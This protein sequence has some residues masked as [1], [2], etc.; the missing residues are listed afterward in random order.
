MK[1]PILTAKAK[2]VK[3]KTKVVYG[4]GVATGIVATVWVRKNIPI[5]I[6]APISTTQLQHLIDHTDDAMTY[7]TRQGSVTLFN[8]INL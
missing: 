2:F 3:H 6:S 5:H 8:D 1:N 4:A 7:V